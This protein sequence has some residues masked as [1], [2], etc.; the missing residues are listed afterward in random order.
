MKRIYR[1]L[2]AILLLTISTITLTSCHCSKS[3]TQK[4]DLTGDWKVVAIDQKT[5]EGVE[6]PTMNIAANKVNGSTG[7]NRYFGGIVIDYKTKAITFDKIG[8]T[9]ML[10][11]EKNAEHDFLN[12]LNDVKNFQ[13][14]TKGGKI[15]LQFTDDSG[16]ERILLTQK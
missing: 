14:K 16:R 4:A 11:A 13:T 5:L 15:M 6:I 2:S 1:L 8:C 7:C 3:A 9:K 10:C 12:A